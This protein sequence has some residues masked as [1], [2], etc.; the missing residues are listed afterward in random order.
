MTDISSTII[1]PGTWK[2]GLYLHERGVGSNPSYDHDIDQEMIWYKRT[3]LPI[4]QAE[5]RLL[6]DGLN[7]EE[8]KCILMEKDNPSVN[9]EI[10]W[11]EKLEEIF[12]GQ[13]LYMKDVHFENEELHN[14]EFLAFVQPFLKYAKLSVSETYQKWNAKHTSFR[15]EESVI[16][17]SVMKATCEGLLTLSMRVLI[18]ELNLARIEGLLNGE[19]PELR[20]ED[21]IDNHITNYKDI[22]RL[23]SKY[24]VLARLMVET[25]ERWKNTVCES[26]EHLINDLTEIQS[27]FGEHY[28]ELIDIQTGSGDLHRD[29]R[30]VLI[31]RF[32]TGD[33]L[34]YKPRSLSI[35]YHFNRLI[36]W[37]NKGITPTL[38]PVQVIDRIDYGWQQFTDHKECESINQVQDFYQRLGSYIAIFH[39]LHATDI[40]MENMVAS[41]EHPQFIDLES[42]FQNFHPIDDTNLTALQKTSEE[43]TQ[44]VL[45]TAI[46]PASLF[47]TGSFRSIEVSGIG[48]HAGQKLPRS[49][50]KFANKKT[51]KMRMTKVAGFHK[52]ANN[53]PMYKG[54]EVPPEDYVD[55]ILVG[56]ERAYMFIVKNKEALLK[57]DGPIIAFQN[58]KVRSI[59]RH[60]QSYTTMLEASL[61]PDNLKNGLDRVQLF[62]YLWRVVEL[63]QKLGHIIP[64]ETR[65]LLKGDVPYFHTQVNSLSVWDSRGKEIEDFYSSSALQHTLSRIQN[66]NRT[67]CQKQIKY[68]RT[69]M[70]TM[71]KR[72]DFK[73]YRSE[74]SMNAP[75]KFS[76]QDEFLQEAITIGDKLL[77]SAFWGDGKDDV[78]WIGV[79][80]SLNN[81][82]LFTPL[83]AT[84]Y[85]G[86]LGVALFYAYLAELSGKDSYKRVSQSAVRSAYD[87]LE[88][89]DGLGSLSAFHGYASVAYVFSHLGVLWKDR[90]YLDEALEALY[91][92]ERWIHKDIMYD[93]IGGVSGTLLVSLRL[94]KITK[95]ER[96]LSIAVKCGEHL[97]QNARAK[98]SGY[99]WVSSMD[100]VTALVGLS[101]GTAG[102]A[103]AL[104]ELYTVT[105]DNRFL[106]YSQ[107]AIT[108]E[109]SRFIAEEGNWADLRYREERK[110]LGI[111]TPVQW[112]HGAAGIALG[113]LM[114]KKHW[115]D[116]KM[117]NEINIA[118]DI[119]LR[120]GFGGSHCQCHG[121]FGNL[122]VLILASENMDDPRLMDRAQQIGT[123]ILQEA[124]A[125]GWFCGIPQNEETPGLML[126][127]A[128]V[129]YGLLRLVD[130]SKVPP[131]VVLGAPAEELV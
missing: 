124:N 94:Y 90:D 107:H 125:N 2:R 128:G 48:G 93:L 115:E 118:V 67:D 68:I 63:N 74:V 9:G 59:L 120:E 98:E 69:S 1:N 23:L 50:Y 25:T 60:T 41:G 14:L 58:D 51:D 83:D 70:A 47:K 62:D 129:G 61:H 121:D 57:E 11:G 44:S 114:T 10:R 97:I 7:Q 3:G 55:H 49:I 22:Y 66:F 16:Q 109:R 108:Y 31:M 117:L 33:R 6:G 89:Y 40:H 5:F 99:G 111:T 102:I 27:T 19:T 35:D 123:S 101:H 56:F 78:S 103:W 91:K 130:P 122:E 32:S 77:E 126:G 39:M 37:L 36:E 20:Y 95:S 76:T 72:W 105:E 34:V 4:S 65:D 85:D 110:R 52:G 17:E 88:R 75:E 13:H 26:V 18:Y 100:N 127:L 131:V 29:G 42:L 43:L 46:L 71:L 92:C 96:A 73:E 113:R 84:L 80:A 54:E 82:W 119:T 86:V 116:G 24:P 104:A 79:G 28:V 8:F 15:M 81:R 106:E 45:R 87:F 112:C 12:N 53:R 38:H 64:S 30:S 21:F